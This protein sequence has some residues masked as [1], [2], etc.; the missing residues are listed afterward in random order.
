MATVLIVDDEPDIRFLLRFSLERAGHDVT[1]AWNGKIA[2]ERIQAEVPD[3]IVTDLMMPV[4]AGK[5]FID[6]L[7]ADPA[8]AE[9][10][11][12]VCTAEPVAQTQGDVTLPKKEAGLGVISA[13]DQLLGR[14]GT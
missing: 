13:V 8:T 5:E 12:I 7:K 9:I 1:E 11:V 6:R 10:P 4:M 14:E 3:V 2:L